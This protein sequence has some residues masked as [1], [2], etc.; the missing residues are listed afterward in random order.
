MAGIAHFAN[1]F[2]YMEEAEHALFRSLGESV[3]PQGE[4]GARTGWPRVEVQCKYRAP[5]RFEDE[6]LIEVLIGRLG[7]KSITYHHKVWG[8]GETLCAEGSVTAV[9]SS[10]DP[11][12]GRLTSIMIPEKLKSQLAEAPFES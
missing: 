8:P 12:T 11:S 10:V 6:M 7:R 4:T 5:L 2:R 1:F 9:C 3:H